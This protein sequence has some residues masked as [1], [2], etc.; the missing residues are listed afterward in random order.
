MIMT[1]SLEFDEFFKK[2]VLPKQLQLKKINP[3]LLQIEE[4]TNPDFIR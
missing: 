2:E 4:A 1:E 3:V